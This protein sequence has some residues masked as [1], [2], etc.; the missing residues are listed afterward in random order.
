MQDVNN[1]ENL[2]EGDLWKLLEL[3][4]HFFHKPKPVQKNKIY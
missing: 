4:T 3:S 1:R 2:V